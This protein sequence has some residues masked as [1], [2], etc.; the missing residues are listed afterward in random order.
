MGAVNKVLSTPLDP[1][2]HLT[3]GS[4]EFWGAA[5]YVYQRW[6]ADQERKAGAG[7]PA[8]TPAT[9]NEDLGLSMDSSVTKRAKKMRGK[10]S[11]LIG[12]GASTGQTTGVGLNL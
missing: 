1:H 10:K 8:A 12:S 11:I 4:P 2:A 7:I 5:S 3:K 9:G 6:K